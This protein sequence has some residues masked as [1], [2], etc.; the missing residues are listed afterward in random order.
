MKKNNPVSIQG[1]SIAV[2]DNNVETALRRLRKRIDADGR[3]KDVQENRYYSKPSEQ[4]RVNKKKAVM[5][6]KRRVMQET[7][8]AV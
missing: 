3:I 6:N 1:L 4:K 8:K 7:Q 2:R 5:R